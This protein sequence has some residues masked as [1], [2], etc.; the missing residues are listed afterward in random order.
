M[1]GRSVPFPDQLPS[2]SWNGPSSARANGSGLMKVK[3]RIRMP[4]IKAAGENGAK[5]RCKG[6][7]PYMF[8]LEGEK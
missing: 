2:N 5:E 7:F 8:G 3:T 6:I 4:P 1:L